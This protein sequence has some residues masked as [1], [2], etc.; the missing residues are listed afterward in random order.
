M[1]DAS[2]RRY[3]GLRLMHLVDG[4]RVCAAIEA[5]LNDVDPRIFDYLVDFAFGDIYAREGNV[6]HREV[7]AVAALAAIGGCEAQLRTHL[8]GAQ[9]VGL[10]Q[11]EILEILVTLIPFVGFPKAMNA[12]TVFRQT[13]RADR[14]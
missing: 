3:R 7:A 12:L 13:F 14:P 1:T 2:G 6:Q 5:Q 4:P 11:A 9:N 8:L 10:S